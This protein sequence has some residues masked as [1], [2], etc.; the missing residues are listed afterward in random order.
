ML[1]KRWPSHFRNYRL[2]KTW[3][4]KNLKSPLSDH[5][6]RVSTSRLPNSA[7]ICTS[8]NFHL[9]FF[10]TLGKIELKN[11]SLTHMSN[12]RTVC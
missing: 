7:K 4:D 1:Q 6:L 10:I 2:R 12:F 3:V 9:F 8:A 11:I 5:S